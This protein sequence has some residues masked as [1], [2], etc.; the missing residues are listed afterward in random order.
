MWMLLRVT[1]PRA[2]THSLM[3]LAVDKIMRG[4]PFLDTTQ[5]EGVKQ[6]FVQRYPDKAVIKDQAVIQRYPDKDVIQ[7]QAVI[8]CFGR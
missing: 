1:K 3:S 5:Q 8:P 7:E 6:S 4:N 2:G